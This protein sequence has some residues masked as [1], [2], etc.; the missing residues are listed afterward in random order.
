MEQ[1]DDPKNHCGWMTVL[2]PAGDGALCCGGVPGGVISI[3]FLGLCWDVPHLDQYFHK[4]LSS[5]LQHH[6][7]SVNLAQISLDLGFQ[8]FKKFSSPE[9]K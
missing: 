5:E 2:S 8:S 9:E 4:F 3:P 6:N 1:S 7:G